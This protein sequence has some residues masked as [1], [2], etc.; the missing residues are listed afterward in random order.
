MSGGF[1]TMAKK[2]LG[3]DIEKSLEVMEELEANLKEF[4]H[5]PIKKGLMS[6]KISDE[7]LVKKINEASEEAF[8]LLNKVQDLK[9]RM[10]GVRPPKNSRFAHKV[11]ARFLESQS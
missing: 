6:N 7:D 11:V 10:S 2:G 5:M 1:F 8:G 4:A 3:R 9:H